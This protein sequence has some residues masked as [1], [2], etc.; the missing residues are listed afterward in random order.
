MSVPWLLLVGPLIIVGASLLAIL[1]LVLVRR[2]SAFQQHFAENEVAGLLFSAMGVVYG[3]LLAFVVFAT[4]ESFAGAQ[5]AVTTE[6]AT[7]VAAYRDTQTFPEPQRTEVQLAYRT[8][9]KAVVN[10][11]AVARQTHGA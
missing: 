4:W 5:Q 6:A 11:V 2:S 1:G 3:A 10:G 9:A 7:L 8:Y